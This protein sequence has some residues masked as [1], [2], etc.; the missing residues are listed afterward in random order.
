MY[1]RIKDLREDK[2]LLQSDIARILHITQQQ[3]S[4]IE[5]GRSEIRADQLIAL[6]LF[7]NKSTDYILGLTNEPGGKQ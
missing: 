4:N 7:Y 5:S 2:D 1:Q 3:Y 6:A